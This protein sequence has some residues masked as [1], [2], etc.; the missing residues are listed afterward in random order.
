MVPRQAM[1]PV[2]FVCVPA[3]QAEQKGIVFGLVPVQ[4][5]AEHALGEYEPAAHGVP[6][7]AVAPVKR[8]YVPPGHGAHAAAPAVCAPAAP[9]VPAAHTVPR[10]AV[11]PA[12][13]LY[14]PGRHAEHVDVATE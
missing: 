10:H 12:A 5:A 2:A 13:L 3:G 1:A 7:H 14:V 9:N 8:M 6:A 4:P 11:R